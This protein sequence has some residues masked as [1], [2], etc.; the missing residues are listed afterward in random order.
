MR[1]LVFDIT[2]LLYRAFY[3]YKTE[4]DQTIAGMAHQ[5]GM[6]TSNKYFTKY[7]PDKVIMCFDR[8]NWRKDYTASK[9]CISGK[10]YK[11]NR[12]LD[13][14][15]K[16]QIKYQNF[17]AHID[18]FETIIRD[19]TTIQALS[20]EGLEADDLVAM[21][22]EYYTMVHEDC[23]TNEIIIISS[24]KDLMQ[25]LAYPHVQLIEPDKGKNRTLDEY[26]GDADL[27]MFEKCLRGDRGDNVQSAY[28][29]IRRTAIL[30]AYE[31]PMLHETIMHHEWTA[32]GP[33]GKTFVVKD[34]FKENQK[35]MDLSK[36]PKEQR[37]HMIQVVMEA[38][39]NPGKF[40]YFH[41]MKFLGEFQMEKLADKADQFV[42]M[43]SA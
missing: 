10:P 6:A 42:K 32:P 33:E 23:D 12:R 40:S 31:D 5:M 41:F 7:K 29:R 21:V 13:M 26:N 8:H 27:F 34:L 19:H 28:P 38:E 37:R 43:L 18:E 20:G 22:V 15:E 17:L 36:Q 3:A 30:E 4:D 16:E 14:T 2:N 11:G 35:L 39:K 24:D 25:L 9:Q 1:Y